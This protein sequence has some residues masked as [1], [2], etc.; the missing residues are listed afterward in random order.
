MKKL[1][2]NEHIHSNFELVHLMRLH[3]D[4]VGQSKVLPCHVMSGV[5]GAGSITIKGK[6]PKH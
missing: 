3:M 2:A 6:D 4:L 5:C 1:G